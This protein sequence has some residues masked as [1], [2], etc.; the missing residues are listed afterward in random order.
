MRT[1]CRAVL[2]LGVL[3]LVVHLAPAQQGRGRGFGGGGVGG[4]LNMKEVQKELNL[5]DDQVE[6]AKKVATDV[7]MKHRD[8]FQALRDVPMEERFAK[9]QELG[10]KVTD[11]TFKELGDTLKPEQ[12]KRLKQLL[13]QQQANGMFGGPRVFMTPPVEKALNLTD[14]QKDDLKTM[15]E[16]YQKEMREMF[17]PGG[18]GFNEETRK[19]M[20]EL[21]KDAM[22]KALKVLDDKQKK[23]WEE[24]V[25]APFKFPPPMRR[26]PGGNG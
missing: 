13:L 19:K 26:G 6:K 17:Q 9:M 10:Q 4:L 5:S 16:D 18:G 1:L 7:Q 23:E 8:D 3:A 22:G 12:T 20:D 24:M 21:R 2:A 15:A 11:E 14:K 25:G